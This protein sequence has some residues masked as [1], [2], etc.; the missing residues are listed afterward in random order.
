MIKEKFEKELSSHKFFLLKYGYLVI[1]VVVLL[2]VAGLN[3]IKIN[4]I[5]VFQM[6]GKY[7]W[8]K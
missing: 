7:F 5:S 4:D 2:L 1:L 6:I 8:R 3:I